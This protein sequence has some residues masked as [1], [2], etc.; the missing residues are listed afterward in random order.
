MQDAVSRATIRIRIRE[1]QLRVIRRGISLLCF[2]LGYRAEGITCYQWPLY[3]TPPRAG[4]GDYDGGLAELVQQL[5][6][7]LVQRGTFRRIQLTAF[8][9]AGCIFAARAAQQQVRHGHMAPLARWSLTRHKQLLEKLENYR[10]RARRL[11]LKTHTVDQ[12][13]E[14]SVRWKQFVRWMRV[15]ILYCRCGRPKGLVPRRWNNAVLDRVEE[16]A[17]R[18][19]QDEGLTVPEAKLLRHCLRLLL[20]YVRRDRTDFGVRTLCECKFWTLQYL[21]RFVEKRCRKLRSPLQRLRADEE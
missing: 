13:Q 9:L 14:M 20:R 7:K 17:R 15:S 2:R 18:G 12:W 21:A 6:E 5:C 8:E 3:L 16:L 1:T 4:R 10:R 19:L 11:F